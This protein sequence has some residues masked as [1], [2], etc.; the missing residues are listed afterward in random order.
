MVCLEAQVAQCR[1][2]VCEPIVSRFYHDT[3]LD[4]RSTLY[5][6]FTPG[7]H[8]GF[9]DVFEI[10]LNNHANHELLIYN[11]WGDLVFESYKNNT[12]DDSLAWNGNVDNVGQPCPSGT[13]FFIL[14]YTFNDALDEEVSTSGTITL[15]RD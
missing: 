7:S 15:I 5:N 2:T 3:S 10:D 1:D 8:D 14:T 13:Y 11:R 12:R 9:N 4:S 6:V